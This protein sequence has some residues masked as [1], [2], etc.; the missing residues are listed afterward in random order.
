VA[1]DLPALTPG[2]VVRAV[3]VSGKWRTAAGVPQNLSGLLRI[4]GSNYASATQA[5]AATT[6]L[7]QF[8]WHLSP[9]TGLVFTEAEVNALEPGMRSV[10]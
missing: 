9:A 1:T 10:T 5:V 2:N 7:L 6:A 3:V 4:S 8:I